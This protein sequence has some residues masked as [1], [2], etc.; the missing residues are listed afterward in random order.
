MIDTETHHGRAN[1]GS[2]L[3]VDPDWGFRS[4]CAALL[5]RNFNVLAA[6]GYAA[7]QRLVR[8]HDVTLLVTEEDI[9]HPGGVE[10]ISSFR[11][12]RLEMMYVM[13]AASIPADA[14]DLVDFAF[15]KPVEPEDLHMFVGAMM[16]DGS[17]CSN[18]GAK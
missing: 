1:S 13:V 8:R 17:R 2:I 14:W 9:G 11:S 12:A 7:A 4:E 18:P 15:T 3:L 5:G 6:D 16:S 10:L